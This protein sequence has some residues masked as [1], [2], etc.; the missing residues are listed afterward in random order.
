M[1]CRECNSCTKG[2]FASQ[3]ES[4]VCIGVKHPF[5][6][7]DVDHECTEYPEKNVSVTCVATIE[8]PKIAEAYVGDDGIYVPSEYDPRYHRMLISKELFVKA[9]DKW[10]RG[11]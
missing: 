7:E 1:K 9:Y 5:V 8:E 6:I 11:L 3:P 4:Y 2:Y 10:I